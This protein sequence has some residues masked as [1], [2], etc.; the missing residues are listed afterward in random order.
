MKIQATAVDGAFILEPE[1]IE[2]ERG[3]FARL[4]DADALAGRGLDTSFVQ[5]S[6]SFNAKRGTLRGLH[7]QAQPF[8]ET[9]IVRCTAGTIYDVVL[10]LR[11]LSPTYLHHDA[12]QLDD[13]DCRSLYVPR[14]CAH[15]FLTLSDSC[16][17]FYLI[18]VPYQS[19]S[20]RG[21]RWN[22]PQF[23]IRWPFA[24]VVISP[25]DASFEDYRPAR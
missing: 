3:W 21:V 7:Y 17:V 1:R 14:G 15:G 12:V 23:G 5:H 16:E 11:P 19:G 25:R 13:K 10:D 8:E 6:A 9:K 18:S 20:A 24:P 2:D 4:F 22:D